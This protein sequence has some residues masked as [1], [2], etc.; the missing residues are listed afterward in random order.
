MVASFLSEATHLK[1]VYE[2]ILT[3]LQAVGVPLLTPYEF[4]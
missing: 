2:L 3:S 4:L 1:L